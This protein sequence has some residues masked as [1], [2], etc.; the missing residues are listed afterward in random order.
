MTQETVELEF[1]KVRVE[2]RMKTI[3]LEDEY[4]TFPDKDRILEAFA[5]CI[6]RGEFD[7]KFEIVVS[8]V[9]E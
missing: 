9:E 3:I 7:D 2:I 1:Y 8:A 6:L 5:Q 4:V